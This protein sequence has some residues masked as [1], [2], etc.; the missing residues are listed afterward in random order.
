V[1]WGRGEAMIATRTMD[2]VV[3]MTADHVVSRRRTLPIASRRKVES[4][5]ILH[6]EAVL[7]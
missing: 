4:G 3:R 1:D 6:T 7:F 2:I 5:M